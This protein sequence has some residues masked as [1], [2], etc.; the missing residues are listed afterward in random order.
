MGTDIL[1]YF[2]S[3]FWQNDARF[4]SQSVQWPNENSRTKN[5][6]LNKTLRFIKSQKEAEKKRRVSG[7]HFESVQL[8]D[9][10]SNPSVQELLNLSNAD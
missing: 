4:M 8:I 5:I 10:Y 3:V 9:L 1:Q 7:L 6:L 2:G